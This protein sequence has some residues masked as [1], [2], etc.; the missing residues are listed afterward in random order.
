[1]TAGEGVV[2]LSP[3]DWVAHPDAEAETERERVGD[4]QPLEVGE[5]VEEGEGVLKEELED[6]I[7]NLENKKDKS[8]NNIK[9]KN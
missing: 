1:V 5:P 2:L 6:L 8:I 7:D 4:V 3:G 9:V